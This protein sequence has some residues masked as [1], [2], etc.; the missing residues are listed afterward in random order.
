[1]FNVPPLRHDSR[2]VVIFHEQSIPAAILEPFLPT[3]EDLLH[4]EQIHAAF[5]IRVPQPDM[6]ELNDHIQLFSAL[7]HPLFG[8]FRRDSVGLAHGHD[9]VVHE[10]ILTEVFKIF[11]HAFHVHVL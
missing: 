2:D 4:L 9:I 10:S 8:I 7:A 3:R 1:M 11:L 6:L 5:R